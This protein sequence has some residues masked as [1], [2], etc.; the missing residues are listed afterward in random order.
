[1]SIYSSYFNHYNTIIAIIIIISYHRNRLGHSYQL[2]II[3]WIII[4]IITEKEVT[5]LSHVVIC[6]FIPA[7]SIRYPRPHK[8]NGFLSRQHVCLG[9]YTYNE[10][11]PVQSTV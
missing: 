4:T 3:S 7:I 8:A 9:K 11:W 2:M 6:S 5:I 10:N 1:M